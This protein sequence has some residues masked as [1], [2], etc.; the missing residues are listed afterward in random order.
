M[1]GRAANARKPDHHQQR[2]TRGRGRVEPKR[3]AQPCFEAQA[4]PRLGPAAFR[5][6]DRAFRPLPI[7]AG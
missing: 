1:G 4:G 3:A 7:E 5:F 6:V 2:R